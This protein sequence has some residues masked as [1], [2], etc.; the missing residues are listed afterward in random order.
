MKSLA[1]TFFLYKCINNKAAE[2]VILTAAKKGEDLI[3]ILFSGL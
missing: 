1:N 2:E 3:R